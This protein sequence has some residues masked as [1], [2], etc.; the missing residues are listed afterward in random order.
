MLQCIGIRERWLRGLLWYTLLYS[1]YCYYKKKKIHNNNNNN[2]TSSWWHNS[3]A[4]GPTLNHRRRRRSRST[5]SYSYAAAETLLSAG[6][7][8]RN[9][10]P[11]V[12]Y[13]IRPVV[14]YFY[15]DVMTSTNDRPDTQW[16][17][18][19]IVTI[20]CVGDIPNTSSEIW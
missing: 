15:T 4:G 20:Y 9:E 3:P 6:L 16:Y 5:G 11:F 18:N 1:F 19:I 12:H 17:D 8:P 10:Q 13:F 14:L 7:W 2:N